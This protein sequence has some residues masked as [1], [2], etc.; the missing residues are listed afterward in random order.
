MLF[1][2]TFTIIWKLDLAN[3]EAP[4]Y[5]FCIQNTFALLIQLF[6]NKTLVYLDLLPSLSICL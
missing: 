5:R 1:K 6:K 2:C 3:A 4:A